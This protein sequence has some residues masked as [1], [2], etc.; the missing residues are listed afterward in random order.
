MWSSNNLENK[1]LSDNYWRVQLGRMIV[2]AN[3]SLE[4]PLEYPWQINVWYELFNQFGG[5]I[6]LVQFQINCR[7]TG[8]EI[9]KS[10]KLELFER[11]LADN[12]ALSDAEDKTSGLLN[13]GG[14]VDLP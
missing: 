4:P 7:K 2:H 8:K 5:Y 9:P 1:T 13:W 6:N 3:S 12:F 14:M 10:S 11:F